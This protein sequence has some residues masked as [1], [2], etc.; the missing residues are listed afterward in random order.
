MSS[1]T[2]DSAHDAKPW[3]SVRTQRSERVRGEGVAAG[4]WHRGHDGGCPGTVSVQPQLGASFPRPGSHEV[5]L[6]Q[7]YWHKAT[8]CGRIIGVRWPWANM[9]PR[10]PATGAVSATMTN[11][12]RD[13]K[14]SRVADT[15]NRRP[16]VVVFTHGVPSCPGHDWSQHSSSS[17]TGQALPCFHSPCLRQSCSLDSRPPVS[18]MGALELVRAASLIHRQRSCFTLRR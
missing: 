18:R 15:D 11:P 13:T 3:S 4:R 17:L 5:A 9:G 1:P 12:P 14:P 7:T 2:H 10:S 16:L 6:C 8:S